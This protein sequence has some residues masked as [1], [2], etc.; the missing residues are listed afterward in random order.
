[1]DGKGREDYYPLIDASDNKLENLDKEKSPEN[2]SCSQHD[3]KDKSKVQ[4]RQR[5]KRLI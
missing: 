3:K 2:H 4:R 5:P 1:M